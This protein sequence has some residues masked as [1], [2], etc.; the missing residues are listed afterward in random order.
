MT[1]TLWYNSPPSEYMAGLPIGTGRLAAMVLGNPNTERVALN[2]EWL[3]RGKT[4]D[5]D[6][7]PKAHWLAE[8]RERLLA[9]KYEEGTKKGN[10]VFGNYTGK[11]ESCNRVAPYQPAGDLHFSLGH[12]AADNYRRELDLKTSLV[13][14]SYHADKKTFRREYLADLVNDRILVRISAD[15][16]FDADLWLARIDDPECNVTTTVTETRIV[17]CGL[18]EEGIEFGITVD[19]AYQ[20]GRTEVD[21]HRLKLI[22]VEKVL[23]GVNVATNAAGED[24]SKTPPAPIGE[25]DALL[26]ENTKAYQQYYNTVVLEID[27]QICDL[28]TDQRMNAVRRGEIDPSLPVLYFN[29]GRYLMIASTACATLP[30]NL[31]GKWNEELNPPWQADYHNDVNLQM[32][33]WPVEAGGLAFATDAL[34]NLIERFVPHARKAAKDLYGCEGVWFPIQTDPWGRATPE[35]FGWAVWIGAAAWLAQHYW[36]HYE[37]GLDEI[38]LRERAY[39]FFKEVAAFYESYLIE[40]DTGTLQIV[41]SQSPENRFVDSGEDF[42]VSLCVSSAMDIELIQDLLGHAIRSA[43][44]LKTD[45]DAP[46]RWKTILQKLP[47]L[48]IGSKGQLLEWNEEFVEQEPGHRHVSHLVGLY[49]MDLFCPKRTPELWKAAETS[50]RQRLKYGGGYTGWSRSWTACLFARLGCAEDA[51]EHLVHLITDF[52]TDSLLDLHPPRIFQIDGN[53]GGT[54][55]VLEMLLQSYHEELYF[56]PALP[57]AWPTG[58]VQGLRARGGF[59]VDLTWRDGALRKAKITSI[60]DRTCRIHDPEKQLRVLDSEEAELGGHVNDLLCFE[61]KANLQYTILPAY[62]EDFVDPTLR[63]HGEIR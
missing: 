35:S 26:A 19:V 37:Y 10:Q 23:L 25:W 27:G 48:K 7:E 44:I 15:K 61:V 20:G 41:P 9:G 8:V 38:F 63:P 18:F 55:A 31:Q 13:T 60:V 36:L 45:S 34:F 54:A 57:S 2:H 1:H 22:G 11:Q 43:E 30:P 59:T 42:P 58:S 17:L 28:P 33:Y 46:E 3:W 56:L 14:V 4:R 21:G 40:D 62:T 29:Y 51:W 12:D 49:P 6:N 32:A 16:S 53:F 39:P 47:P 52:A 24:D 50:L 5:R